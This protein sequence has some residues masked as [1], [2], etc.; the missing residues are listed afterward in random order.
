MVSTMGSAM[1]LRLG[2]S[3]TAQLFSKVCYHIDEAS[4]RN[5]ACSREKLQVGHLLK[6]DH[7]GLILQSMGGELGIRKVH[8]P[9]HGHRQKPDERLTGYLT[10]RFARRYSYCDRWKQA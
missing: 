1:L 5:E 6:V 10:V 9:P 4:C 2:S 8:I 3:R 7:V